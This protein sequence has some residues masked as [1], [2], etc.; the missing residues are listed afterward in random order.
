MTC[1]VAI[2]HL[3][4]TEAQIEGY[5][6]QYRLQ[7]VLRSESDRQALVAGVENGVIDVVSATMH[8]AYSRQTIAICPSKARH[9]NPKPVASV[10]D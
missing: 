9:R 2:S 7:P 10:H 4:W 3:I 6:F 1:D 5:D 8:L